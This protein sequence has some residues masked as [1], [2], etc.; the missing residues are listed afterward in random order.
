MDL[1]ILNHGQLTGTTSEMAF[2]S[3]NYQTIP[4]GGRLSDGIFSMHWRLLRSRGSQVVK[5]SDHGWRVMSSSPEPL[6]T[7]RV[8]QRCTFKSVESS[9]IHPWG[10]VGW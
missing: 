4:K 9:N 10:G 8:G 3:P 5:V 6:K 7:R 1:V 2:L